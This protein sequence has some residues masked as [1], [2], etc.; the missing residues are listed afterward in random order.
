MVRLKKAIPKG[1]LFLTVVKICQDVTT[2][3]PFE[4]KECGVRSLKAED[5]G[6]Q[7]NGSAARTQISSQCVLKTIKY[8]HLI[9]KK[10]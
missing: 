1:S 4:L 2:I 9:H 5:E 6:R 7:R 3:T 8:K 10:N